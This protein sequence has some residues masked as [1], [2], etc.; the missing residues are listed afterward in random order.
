[1]VRKHITIN[2]EKVSEYSDLVCKYIFKKGK[3]NGDRCYV[4][5][6][7]NGYCLKHFKLV[8]K[9]AHKRDNRLNKEKIKKVPEK[10]KYN[11]LIC[12]YNDTIYKKDISKIKI[13]DNI[14]VNKTSSPLLLCFHNDNTLFNEYIKKNKKKIKNKNKKKKQKAKKNNLK[15]SLI[16]DFNAINKYL[17]CC[18]ISFLNVEE[19]E[20]NIEVCEHIRIN[21]FNNILSKKI[22]LFDMSLE[23]LQKLNI[24]LSEY[25]KKYNLEDKYKIFY[26]K[27]LLFYAEFRRKINNEPKCYENLINTIYDKEV[28]KFMD[29]MYD[30]ILIPPIIINDIN[31]T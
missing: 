13:I 5:N 15:K 30:N 3:S 17:Y 7:C 12:Y 29:V 27:R 8:Q 4:R 9:V 19:I 14:L 6:Y 22:N 20:E 2:I 25:S 21:I 23:L 16:K 11:K 28:E 24:Y 1:M 31:I 18:M 10:N 26:N